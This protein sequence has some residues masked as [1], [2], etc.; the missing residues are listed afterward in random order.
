MITCC[1]QTQSFPPSAVHISLLF[2]KNYFDRPEARGPF[3]AQGSLDLVQSRCILG[4]CIRHW[5]KAT[6]QSPTLSLSAPCEHHSIRIID[7]ILI[8]ANCWRFELIFYR[9]T[10]ILLTRQR[11]H[12][13]QI[14]NQTI[15][16]GP[17]FAEARG[18]CPA[19]PGVN[20]ALII[21]MHREAL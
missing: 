3:A 5:T 17:L 10:C 11:N 2:W 13:K 21:Y 6:K 1:P 20:P 7:L 9:A 16:G 15:C 12:T 14:D 19:C 8:A 4:T 18:T